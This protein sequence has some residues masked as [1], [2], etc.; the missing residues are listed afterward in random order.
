MNI[1]DIMGPVM[2]GPSS[3]HTAG[4][5]RIGYVAR[6]LLYE[7]VKTAEILLHGSFLA[8][9]KGHGTDKGLVAGLLGMGTDDRRIPHSFHIAKERGMSFSF[10]GIELKDAHPNSVL[11]NLVGVNGNQMQIGASSLGG[12]MIVINQ[13]DGVNTN[14][15]ARYPTLIIHNED[16]PG[17]VA[18]VSYQL[19][20]AGINIGTMYLHRDKRGGDA[21]MVIECDDE[22]PKHMIDELKNMKGINKVTYY[23][24]E[25]PHEL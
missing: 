9:G 3:S 15:S 7:D 18:E 5:V 6:Q 17:Y 21:I 14:F 19:G 25:V 8:T 11:M 4:A 1:F 10:G 20:K 2:V 12:G 16:E 22:I 13:I 23:S 24:M